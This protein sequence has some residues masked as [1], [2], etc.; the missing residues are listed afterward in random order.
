MSMN[1]QRDL[2]LFARFGLS[3]EQVE[4]DAATVESE[5]MSDE[6]TGRV[7]YGLHLTPREQEM[8]AISLRLPQADLDRLTAR[9]K[10]YHISRSEYMRRVLANA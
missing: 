8:T 10:Q 1:T 3:S 2:D 5:T 4:R 7:Y 6:L 9:A